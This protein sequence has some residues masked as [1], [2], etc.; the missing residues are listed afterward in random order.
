MS[1]RPVREFNIA[2][3]PTIKEIFL[4]KNYY[5]INYSINIYIVGKFYLLGLISKFPKSKEAY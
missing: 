3:L 4:F 5:R 2:P 1:H